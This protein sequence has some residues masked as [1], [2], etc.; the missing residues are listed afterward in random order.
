M[1][2]HPFASL[3]QAERSDLRT[4]LLST[5]VETLYFAWQRD[6][7]LSLDEI[8]SAVLAAWPHAPQAEIHR[9]V[10]RLESTG[11]IEMATPGTWRRTDQPAPPVLLRVCEHDGC[12][13]PERHPGGHLPDAD[14]ERL[15]VELVA[16]HDDF[17]AAWAPGEPAVRIYPGSA[18]RSATALPVSYVPVPHPLGFTADTLVDVLRAWLGQDE[19]SATRHGWEVGQ[20]DGPDL[21]PGTLVCRHSD[22]VAVWEHSAQ[23]VDIYPDVTAWD[24]GENPMAALPVADGTPFTGGELGRMAERWYL[25]PDDGE[26]VRP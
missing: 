10:A 19:H 2:L 8:T 20:L 5:V 16:Y 13:R 1:G 6:G 9:A 24:D 11:R 23:V 3:P 21:A 4:A 18:P 14:I 7:S 25:A 26:Q 12:L 22:Y 15:R 17:S